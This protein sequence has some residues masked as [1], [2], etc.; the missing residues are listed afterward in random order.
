MTKQA[1]SN[2]Y[3]P[4]SCYTTNPTDERQSKV[5]LINLNQNQLNQK[6]RALEDVHTTLFGEE[7]NSKVTLI[8]QSNRTNIRELE[9]NK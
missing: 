9:T 3:I 2:V 7:F 1:R 8:E 5:D 4:Y 6:K